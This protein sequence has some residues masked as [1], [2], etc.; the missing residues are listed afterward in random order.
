MNLIV[1]SLRSRVL[2]CIC[3]V[4]YLAV[5]GTCADHASITVVYAD[6]DRQGGSTLDF[7]EKATGT[8]DDALFRQLYAF[9][10][11]ENE[12]ISVVMTRL[13]GDLDPYLV[14]TNESG[15]IL[16][17]SDDD[18]T[19]TNAEIPFKRLPVDGRY[20]IIVTRFGQEHGTT[21]GE[22]SLEL[23][24]VGTE[25]DENTVL[26][27]G[28]SVFG[29]VTSQEPTA[30]YFLRAQRGDVINVSMRRTS[31]DL[32]PQLELAT[33]DGLVLV[34]NDDDPNAEGTLDAEISTYTILEDGVY[35]VIA[36]RFGR[37]SGQT[38][39]SYVLFVERIPVESLGTAPE[40][41]R[42]IDYGATHSGTIDD[43]IFA[44]FF[45]FQANRGDVITA[46]L[47]GTSGDLD[48]ALKLMSSDLNELARDDD[49]GDGRDARI[50]GFTIPATAKYY[51]VATRSDEQ[52][53]RTEGEFALEISGRPG[54]A[55]GQALEI[56]YGATVSGRI[57]STTATEEYLFFGQ[58]GDT[59]RI[60]MSRASGDLDSLVTLYD[61][62]RKQIAFDDDSGEEKDA[63]IS[64]Y[65]LPRDDMYI[66]AASRFE[67]ELGQTSGAYILTLELLR[68][69]R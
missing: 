57:D 48:P 39:G 68:S 47:S 42:L 14:V 6:R 22:Y 12:V 3:L 16:A 50:A 31:G 58:Q 20:F 15:A 9:D 67:R 29:R 52:D 25:A 40:N 63:L 11:R 13:N 35:L 43:T 56:M 61:S 30:F 21:A 37:E 49:S 26:Q 62:D 34:T 1:Y 38:E 19:S 45:H 23:E 17:L 44:R 66:L 18:G 69:A 10:G 24:R 60:T 32:D 53:G 65:V 33:T 36:T 27:Y 46:T 4:M 28:D 2:W 8:L 51:L 5:V 7:G 55:G 59:I 64:N 41:A 54:V